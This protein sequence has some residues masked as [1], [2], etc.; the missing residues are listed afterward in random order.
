MY[1]NVARLRLV[2]CAAKQRGRSAAKVEIRGE[3]SCLPSRDWLGGILHITRTT[4]RMNRGDSERR[5]GKPEG[6]PRALGD[7]TLLGAKDLR[8]ACDEI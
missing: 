3:M 7:A 6:L 4:Q 2:V 8:C 1:H 5:A